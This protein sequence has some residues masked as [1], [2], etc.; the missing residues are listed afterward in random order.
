MTFTSASKYP[1]QLFQSINT[2]TR[3][4]FTEGG[5]NKKEIQQNLR[6][7]FLF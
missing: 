1:E 4:L 5:L 6:N 7:N 2:L 3:F